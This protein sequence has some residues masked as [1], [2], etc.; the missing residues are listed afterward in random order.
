MSWVILVL[1][2]IV[3][4]YVIYNRSKVSS[5]Y[6]PEKIKELTAEQ[7]KTIDKEI[8]RVSQ[9]GGRLSTPLLLKNFEESKAEHR[10][11]Q[12]F[13]AVIDNTKKEIMKKYDS[14]IHPEDAFY[15]NGEMIIWNEYPG[16]FE[17]HLQR[18]YKNVLFPP[19]RR[20]ISKKDIEEAR[21][22]DK[23]D[24]DIFIKAVK[25]LGAEGELSEEKIPLS[26]VK[27][28]TA[29]Q[30]V[31]AMLVQGASIGGNIQDA[32]LVLENLEKKL[33]EYMSKL[34]PDA[35]ELL[36]Q[37]T[38]L[39]IVERNQ[40]MAQSKRKDTPILKEEEVP[41]LLSEDLA[42]I[43]GMGLASRSFAPNFRPNE[44]D[45]KKH[46]DDAISQGFSKDRAREIIDAWNYN[47]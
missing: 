11:D 39:S 43:A 28:S 32:I 27:D 18:R 12:R 46:L 30:K 8:K 29:L 2:L 37:A 9:Q 31:Q 41:T 33:I 35:K 5:H 42:T 16:C 17:R 25:N 24:E 36:E 40:Y 6:S 3:I 10:G 47:R 21:G 7:M 14:Y 22:K 38:S 4:G 45:I 23:I 20:H 26:T 34:A 1:V 19:E 15:E 44:A 13:I